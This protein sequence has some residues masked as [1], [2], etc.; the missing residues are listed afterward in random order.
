MSSTDFEAGRDPRP[1]EISRPG[2]DAQPTIIVD[3]DVRRKKEKTSPTERIEARADRHIAE[4]QANRRD[5]LE[6]IRNLRTSEVPHLRADIRWLEGRLAW[7]R[8]AL[9]RLQT[10]YEWAI[11]FSWFSFALVTIGGVVVSFASFIPL[12]PIAQKI[13]A[14]AGFIGLLI[15]VSVQALSSSRGSR[16]L[17]KNSEP[18]SDDS[19]PG[20]GPPPDIVSRSLNR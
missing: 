5:L 15:G 9:V 14:T 13:I 1:P 16:A 8:E 20:P 10:A 6:D 17:L 12:N 11:A 2:P 7:H 3:A 19:R 18:R 4:L